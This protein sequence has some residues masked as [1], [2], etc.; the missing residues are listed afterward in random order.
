MARRARRAQARSNP[1]LAFQDDALLN[2]D[3]ATQN[4]VL[5]QMRAAGGKNIRLNAIWGQARANG[6]YDWGKLD[7]LVNAARARGIAPQLTLTGTPEYMRARNADMALSAGTPNQNL[8]GAFAR[9]AATHFRGRVKRYSIWNEPNISSFLAEGE[10][11]AGP[12]QYRRLYQSG[13]KGVKGADPHAQVLLGELTAGREGAPGR[14]QAL[15][16]LRRVLAA[17]NKPLLADGLALH[18]YQWSNPNK[19]MHDANYGGI[20]NL[21]MVQK[22]LL[23]EFHRGKLATP[24]G[25]TK[26]PLYLT[27]M[28]Y[29]GAQFD[30]PTRAKYLEQAYRLAQKAGAKQFLQ[31]QWLP[32]TST[33]M[34]AQNAVQVQGNATQ[35]Q[36]MYGRMHQQAGPFSLVQPPPKAVVTQG[37]PW[38][39]SVADA[40]GRLDP[41]F[42]AAMRRMRKGR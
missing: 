38:D 18:P 33:T 8:M 16:F 15:G 27:E 5:D 2:A 28:G 29:K 25:K 41:R 3:A 4:R 1:A 13:Y 36:D 19:Q 23:R 14:T 22:E 12:K 42:A 20:S 34:Q 26:V 17:G 21:P 40:S 6:A 9:D 31:Y 11:K 32:T 10:N 37:G 30:T 7:T 39:T 35:T 24:Q